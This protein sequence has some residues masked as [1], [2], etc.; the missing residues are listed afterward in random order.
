MLR[1]F[2]KILHMKKSFRSPIKGIENLENRQIEYLDIVEKDGNPYQKMIVFRVN[3]L[4]TIILSDSIG[5]ITKLK[6]TR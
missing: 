5:H 3:Q 4:R 2:V 6:T 1:F